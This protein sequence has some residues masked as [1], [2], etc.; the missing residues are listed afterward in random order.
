MTPKERLDKI[1]VT[2]DDYGEEL[3]ADSDFRDNMMF[4]LA[5]YLN[6]GADLTDEELVVLEKFIK[7]KI[8]NIV[9]TKGN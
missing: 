4:L 5:R 6:E 1:I 7:E 8:E 2:M 9:K 3:W